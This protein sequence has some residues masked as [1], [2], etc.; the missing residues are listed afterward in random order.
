M[1][2]MEI[3][4]YFPYFLLIL[5]PTVGW[6]VQLLIDALQVCFSASWWKGSWKKEIR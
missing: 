3:K 1:K 5:P 2:K 4:Y 6:R